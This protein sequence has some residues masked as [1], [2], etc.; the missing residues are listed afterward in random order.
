MSNPITLWARMALLRALACFCLMVGVP[1]SKAALFQ[2]LTATDPGS[3]A[4]NASNVVTAWAD[5]SGNANHASA[6]SGSVTYSGGDLFPVGTAGV[7]FG[8]SAASLQLLN[9]TLASSMLD[10]T[11]TTGA[12]SANTGFAALVSVRV[13]QL[14]TDWSDLLGVTSATSGGFGLRYSSTGVIQAYMGTVTVQRPGSDRAVCAGGSIV[15]AVN[16]D[17]STGVLTLWDSLNNSEVTKTIPKGNF[18]GTSKTLRLGSMDNASRFVIGSVGEAK[19]Y[20]NKLSASDFSTQRD[21]MTLAWIGARPVMPTMP[22]VPSWTIAQLLAWTTTSDADAPFNVATVPLQNRIN[23]PTALQANANAKS[24]Q[25]GIQALDT[26]SGDKPQGGGGSIDY[27]FTYWQYLEQSVYWGGIGAI[28]FV[29]PTAEMIDNAHRNGVPILGTI[30][31]P[32]LVY[33]GNYSWVQTFLTKSGSTYP[34]ADKLIATAQYY[35]F[36]GWF[37]NQETAGGT[38]SDAAA[39]RDLV[40]YM[41]QNSSLRVTWYDSMTEAGTIDWQDQFNTSNDWYLRHNY[42]NGLQDSNGDLIA[43]SIFADFSDDTTAALPQNSRNRADALLL[44][45]YKVWTGLET[46]AEDF[47]TSTA[48]RIKMAKAFPNGLDHLT[49][50][51]LYRPRTFATSLSNQ[52]LFWTGAGGDPRNTSATVGTGAWK[53]VAHHV[54]ERSVIDSLPFATDFCTGQGSNF[55]DDGVLVKAGAWWNRALQGILP[56]WRWIIDST[57]TKLTP[58]LSSIDSYRGGSCLR[59]SGNLD[60]E[61]TL[62]LYLTNLPVTSDTRLKIV[63]KRNGLSNVDSLMQVGVSTS[64]APTTFTYYPA[65]D[66]TTSGWNQSTINLSGLSGSTIAALALKFA[67]GATVS[68][69]EIRIG[70]IVVY[71][72]TGTVA[73]APTNVQ[74]L[75]VATWAGLAS[76]RVKWDHA[77]GDHYAYNVYL[78]L[79]DGSLVFAGSTTSNYFYF[80]DIAISDTY[81]A[82]VVQAIGS[83]TTESRLSDAPAISTN[84]FWDA[85]INDMPITAGSGNWSTTVGNNTSNTIWNDGSSNVSWYQAST[86]VPLN[87]STFAG[88]DGTVDQYGVTLDSQIAV[89]ALTFNSTGYKLTGGTVYAAPASGNAVTVAAGKSA[90][91]NSNLTTVMSPVQ[92]VA[93]GSGSVLNLGGNLT[94]QYNFGGAGS[95]NITSGTSAPT[96]PRFNTAATNQ[97]GGTMTVG[98]GGS[99]VGYSAGQNT[100]Y[101]ISGGTLSVNGAT[102]AYLGLGR[103]GNTATLTVKTGGTLNVGTVATQYGNLYIAGSDTSA[104]GK[105]DVQGGH[106]T[107]GT[108]QAGNI[109][110]FFNPG[111]AGSGANQAATMTQSGGT[112]TLN[113]IRF[114]GTGGT[115]NASSLAKLQVSGGSL[116]VGSNGINLGSGAATLPYLIQLQGGTLGA[117]ADWSSSLNMKLGAGG[118]VIQAADSGNTARNISLSGVLSND[119]TA[120]TLTKTGAGTLTLS[121]N[122]THTGAT[123][124]NAGTLAL[125][126]TFTNNLNA[127]PWLEVAS[128]AILNVTGL[129]SGRLLLASGQ[130]LKG[131][132]TVTGNVTV[133]GTARLS[134]GTSVGQLSIAGALDISA[135]GVGMLSYE[136][137]TLAGTNDKVTVTGALPIGN[138][139]LGFNDFA[140]TDLGGLEVGTYKL[141]ASGGLTGTLDSTNL[142]GTIGAFTGTLRVTGN[143]LELVVN[144]APT[145]SAISDLSVPS[146]GNT[147]VLAFSVGD[148]QSA[149]SSLTLTGGSSNLTL[150][151]IGNI[152]FGGSGANRTV[153]VTPIPGLTGTATITVTVGDGSLTTPETFILTVTA[154]YLAWTFSNGITGALATGDFDN[155]GA[156]NLI[157]YALGTDPKVSSQAAGILSGNVI[158]YQK[159]ADA[160]ANGDVSWVIETSLTLA[161]GSWIPQVTQAAG[162]RAATISYALTPGTPSNK[163]VRLRMTQA[164]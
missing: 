106:L 50:V 11:P 39:M 25:G 132:G 71:N 128:A 137:N 48:G 29:P 98:S 134:P 123:T 2:S 158:I 112:V 53:G 60:A 147:G 93:I 15:F 146:G 33:G 38:A 74:A 40:R 12:A 119:T 111:T 64:A 35:G 109:L 97:T 86:T 160:I 139:A 131:S 103:A 159:G 3:I 124:I 151:P 142:T 161:A 125:S 114:G 83:D 155:D 54:A 42:T 133:A 96:T 36:D 77:A 66:C 104:S 72:T 130:T 101:A 22:G 51:G 58:E 92:A 89:S 4:R 26:Y 113:G 67:S 129:T 24:G 7:H 43:D 156:A 37:F 76:G 44:S 57:G 117:S 115:Y 79:A 52:D 78:R 80:Q 18:A 23:V 73:V 150:V 46:E 6:G 105:L 28:N 100:N 61:N 31:F 84:L 81:S 27:T 102:G 59:V 16:Y 149:A 162:N 154:N 13:D 19:L 164:R 70:Q 21:A 141:I 30:F 118:A 121:G 153:T 148:T 20:T 49:S 17:A 47:R 152:V 14:N 91:I 95:L 69:Y 45:P 126:G 82:I 68:S 99:W 88:T 1:S 108:S 85:S 94:G 87:S 163:F 65:G 138:G 110:N 145:I 90:T 120:G 10:F 8:P 62:R 107:I 116:Y 63:F 34:A 144:A 5:K 55:Y 41:R 140:F 56:T 122:N 75:N 32:P 9:T 135:V 157:E 143:D 127:S 136:L